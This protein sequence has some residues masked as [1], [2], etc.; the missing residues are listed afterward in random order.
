MVRKTRKT[1]TMNRVLH[2]RASVAR[3]YLARNEGRRRQN[4]VEE[5]IRSEENGL[6]DNIKHKEKGYNWLL[7]GFTKEDTKKENKKKQKGQKRKRME[8]ESSAWTVPYI[9]RNTACE[10]GRLTNGSEATDT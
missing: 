2:P 4:S 8:R 9:N 7:R 1:L 3:L 10:D 6:F 5:T